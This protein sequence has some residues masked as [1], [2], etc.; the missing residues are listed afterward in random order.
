MSG[1]FDALFKTCMRS[2]TRAIQSPIQTGLSKEEIEKLLRHGAYDIFNEE[3]A[4]KGDKESEAFISADIDSILSRAKTVV[5][6]NTGSQSGVAGGTFSKASFKVPASASKTSGA[7]DTAVEDVDIDDP[8]FWA[9]MVGEAKDESESPLVAKKRRRFNGNYQEA[10]EGDLPLPASDSE[11]SKVSS[12]S[13]DED[14]S[15]DID[16]AMGERQRWGGTRSIDWDRKDVEK[17][18]RSLLQYGYRMDHITQSLS[19][20]KACKHN[21]EEVSN[22]RFCYPCCLDPAHYK[23]I[24]FF[25]T[26]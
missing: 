14:L 20:N 1:V 2:R 24:C 9:K 11:A 13:S 17:V 26:D 12:D 10:R 15:E 25:L 4:G 21:G 6:D 3:K 22:T 8:E 16:K 5:H 23:H 19:K 18:I 7:D